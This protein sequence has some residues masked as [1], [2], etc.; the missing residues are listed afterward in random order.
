MI[1]LA[2]YDK[3]ADQRL[4]IGRAPTYVY[5][6]GRGHSGSTLLTL[7]MALH[8]RV[9]AVGELSLLSLQ[10]A[11]DETTRWVGQCSCG[12]RPLDCE[13]WG[14]LLE[15]IEA[16]EGVDFRRDPFSW[17]ASDVGMEEEFRGAAPFRAPFAWLRNR[18]WRLMRYWQYLWPEGIGKLLSF[19]KPQ[20]RW[21]MRRSK[22]ASKLAAL[23]DVDAIVDASKDPLDMLDLYY[24]ATVPVRVVFLTRDARGNAW[25]MLK[26]IKNSQSRSEAIRPAAREWNKVNGRIW[27]LFQRIDPQHR[28]HLRYEDICREPAAAM[29]RL[30][31]FLD[32]EP[33]DVVTSTGETGVESDP[34][35]TIGGNKIRFT[36]ERLRIRE[37]TAWKTNLTAEELSTIDSVTGP[38]SRDLGYD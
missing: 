37:D 33:V 24:H 18:L 14:R 30:F 28:L 4:P 5:I 34:A 3:Y 20:V 13:V 2:S 22:L 36:G 8:P 7:L 17:R 26:R 38:L 35:H 27:R 15:E 16:E 32:L 6:A 12:E 31:E 23:H 11:R 9:A 1:A 19:Y 10:L 29:N 21:A 25:S